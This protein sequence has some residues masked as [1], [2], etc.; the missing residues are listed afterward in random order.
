MLSL[1]VNRAGYGKE[2]SQQMNVHVDDVYNVTGTKLE[3]WNHFVCKRLS[4][5]SPT[6]YKY[7]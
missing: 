5:L 3:Q 6:L 2:Y 4:T 7:V 1:C